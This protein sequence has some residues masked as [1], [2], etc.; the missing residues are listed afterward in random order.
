MNRI[1]DIIRKIIH[2]LPKNRQNLMFSA[3]FSDSVQEAAQAFLKDYLFFT[4]GLVGAICGDIELA[5]HEVESTSKRETLEEILGKED[6]DPTERTMIFV[7][8][9]I[10][11]FGFF[12]L[13]ISF[14]KRQLPTI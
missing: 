6:R 1:S 5:F 8:V 3:T 12:L 2:L 14:R 11:V 7:G 13:I 4:V 9:R 10:L